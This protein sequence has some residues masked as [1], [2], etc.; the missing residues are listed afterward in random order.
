METGD[1]PSTIPWEWLL[2]EQSIQG[3]G[4]VRSSLSQQLGVQPG[5][6]QAPE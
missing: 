5:T 1:H 3:L 4:Y 2:A 6:L